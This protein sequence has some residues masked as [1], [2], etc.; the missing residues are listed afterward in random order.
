MA[1][2]ALDEAE[3]ILWEH[4]VSPLEPQQEQELDRI[5]EAARK[6]TSKHP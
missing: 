3:R 5:M 6:E 4:E 1:D 2:N